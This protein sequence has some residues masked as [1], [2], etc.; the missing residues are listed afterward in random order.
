[1]TVSGVSCR[2]L[3]P[4]AT[5]FIVMQTAY[6]AKD[7][8]VTI[9]LPALLKRELQTRARRERRSLSAQITASLEREIASTPGGGGRKGKLLGL[10]AGTPVP[11][12]RDLTRVRRLLWGS[13][14]R[15]RAGGAS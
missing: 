11:S 9:R 14:G 15:K 13:L 5:V 12:E 8:A 10:F 6:M 2:R 1:M 4:V 3:A 7:A